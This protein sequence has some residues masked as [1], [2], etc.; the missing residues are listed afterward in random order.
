MK[1]IIIEDNYNHYQCIVNMLKDSE[2]GLKIEGQGVEIIPKNENSF[3]ELRNNINMTASCDENTSEEAKIYL[4]DLMDGVDYAIIDYKL[5][6]DNIYLN[7]LEIY[8]LVGLHIK[9]L[10]YTNLVASRWDEMNEKIIAEGFGENIKGL[11]EPT[12]FTKV[13]MYD[14]N[15]MRFISEIQ[16]HYMSD[17][18]SINIGNQLVPPL[19]KK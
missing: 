1:I 16:S 9:A 18:Q 19:I 15:I 17:K 8:K 3:I 10:I 11:Q 4:K 7:G 2:K 13:C 5:N 6:E 12:S 14:K